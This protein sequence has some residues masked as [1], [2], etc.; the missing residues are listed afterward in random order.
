MWNVVKPLGHHKTVA[1]VIQNNFA[2]KAKKQTHQCHS[3]SHWPLWVMLER[4][5]NNNL[6]QPN[7]ISWNVR[8]EEIW[9]RYIFYRLSISLFYIL[10][11]ILFS[12]CGQQEKILESTQVVQEETEILR[13]WWFWWGVGA[14]EGCVA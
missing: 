13:G 7:T 5:R 8:K 1:F 11:V 9:S 2:A 10:V 12:C 14:G 3:P 4:S 6:N